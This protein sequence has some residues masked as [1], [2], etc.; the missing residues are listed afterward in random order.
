MI[1]GG[2][3]FR[4]RAIRLFAVI[5]AVLVLALAAFVLR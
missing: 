3:M 2:V 5:L 1:E 4:D